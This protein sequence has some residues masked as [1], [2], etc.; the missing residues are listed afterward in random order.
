MAL[1]RF[2]VKRR[3][4]R[5]AQTGRE[6]WQVTDG[7]FECVA[8]YMDKCAWSRD[9]R[10]LVFMCNR[11]GAWQP[12]RLDIETGEAVQ[13]FASSGA[14][15]RSVAV[16]PAHGEAYCQ[17][18]A[19]LVAVDLETL[20][21][22]RAV[23]FSRFLARGAGKGLA[24]SLSRDGGRVALSWRDPQGRG[25]VLAAPTDGS[26]AVDVVLLPRDDIYPGH[27]LICPGRDDIVSFHGYPDRQNKP[28][29]TQDHRVA[30]WRFELSTRAMKPL[31]LMPRG[32]RATHCLWG[33][34]G[35]RFY[36]HRKTVPQWVPTA[37]GSVDRDG[38]DERIYY[39]TSEHKLGH[40]A[41]SPDEQWIV[42]DS[43]DP[44]K[45]ILMLVSTVRNE[46]HMLCW[47]DASIGSGRPDRRPVSLPPHTD[48]HT[49]P[50]F[51][52]TG[53][54][55]HYTSD[56][57]GCSQVYVAPVADLTGA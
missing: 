10:W 32:F 8:P 54:Y 16:D 29:E 24:A 26:N 6:V 40:S 42:T 15:F 27:E 33:G 25:A 49:H 20:E 52:V 1:D 43:Q 11:T 12:Y 48:R 23:D 51:S 55:V 46:Q 37:L 3:A 56:V 47:P 34:S 53:R 18:G 28:D 44:D 30:Q 5:D 13:L 50:G 31:V 21:P 19:A 57:S 7:E 36:F 14:V 35:E 22:R 41:P 39:E 45:N 2:H 4:F 38:G 9:D 17:D